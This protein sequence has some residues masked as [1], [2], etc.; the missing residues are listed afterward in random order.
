MKMAFVLF[1]GFG[2]REE[3]DRLSLRDAWSGGA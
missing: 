3:T 2:G 1:D